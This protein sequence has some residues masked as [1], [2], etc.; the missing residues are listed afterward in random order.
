[1]HIKSEKEKEYLVNDIKFF[2]P[3]DKTFCLGR[4]REEAAEIVMC[5]AE[6]KLSVSKARCATNVGMAISRM[7]KADEAL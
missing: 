6:C 5:I 3:K 4:N 2:S 7:P 1:M